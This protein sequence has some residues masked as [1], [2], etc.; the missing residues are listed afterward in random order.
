MSGDITASGNM[1]A[2]TPTAPNHLA[3]KAYV[4]A[5]VVSAGGGLTVYQNDGVTVVG[6][7][8]SIGT[9]TPRWSFEPA[10]GVVY[11]T[12]GSGSVTT[13]DY[14]DQSNA[15]FLAM[16]NVYFPNTTCAGIQMYD[17]PG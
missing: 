3:T 7:F 4:D 11:Y 8:L 6:K 5:Q 1:I 15:R 16:P 9:R 10:D 2:A 17:A 13:L 14:T 12:N